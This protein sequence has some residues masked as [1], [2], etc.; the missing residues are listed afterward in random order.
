MPR[1]AKIDEAALSAFGLWLLSRLRQRRMTLGEAARESAINESYLQKILKSYQPQYR[2][3]RRP[4]YEKTVALGR[5]LGDV[6]GAIQSAGY[7][8]GAPMGGADGPP[9]GASGSEAATD[10]LNAASPRFALADSARGSESVPQNAEEWPPELL[11]AMHYSQ[12]LP[13]DV[14]HYIYGLWREQARV[15]SALERSRLEAGIGFREQGQ[16]GKKGE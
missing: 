14:Q 2:C 11:E 1:T 4:S 12:T 9:A 10:A 7:P 16:P 13:E 6:A 3:Y 8:D 5:C 15:Y